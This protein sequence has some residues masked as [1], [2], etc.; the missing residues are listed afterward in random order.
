MS[1]SDGAAGRT[2]GLRGGTQVLVKL[3]NQGSSLVDGGFKGG[4]PK[5]VAHGV[6]ALGGLK[7]KV[8]RLALGFQGFQ[9]GARLPECHQ[10]DVIGSDDAQC[11]GAGKPEFC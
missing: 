10:T 9:E 4:L 1:A 6:Q 7:P 5:N 2:G 3:T 8:K 11:G